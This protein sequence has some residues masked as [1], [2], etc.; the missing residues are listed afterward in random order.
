MAERQ[1]GRRLHHRPA[2]GVDVSCA[3]AVQAQP[4]HLDLLFPSMPL[5]APVSCL[6]GAR[7]LHIWLVPGPGTHAGGRQGERAQGAPA[8]HQHR[9]QHQQQQRWRH[10]TCQCAVPPLP[11]LA[12][13][14]HGMMV[15]LQVA[16]GSMKLTG[17]LGET[18]SKAAGVLAAGVTT[19]VGSTQQRVSGTEPC[20]DYLQLQ[21]L[22][23]P[24][25]QA[26]LHQPCSTRQVV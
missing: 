25:Y 4:F 3:G 5:S 9:P 2:R 12:V 6:L 7:R 22:H 1:P 8:A 17:A 10:R 15:L 14:C 24:V 13:L 18:T 11:T 26:A 16:D 19:A 21:L 23:A 20:L